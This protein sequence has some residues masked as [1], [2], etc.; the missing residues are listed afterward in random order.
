[1]KLLRYPPVRYELAPPGSFGIQ[2]ARLDSN[3]AQ[4]KHELGVPHSDAYFVLLVLT[5]GAVRLQLDFVDTHLMAPALLL[6]QPGQ[7]HYLTHAHDP[8]GYVVSFYPTQV[9]AELG[10]VLAQ[11]LVT[12]PSF[13]GGT[14]PA[15]LAAADLLTLILVGPPDAYRLLAA[16]AALTTLLTLC[17]SLV[18]QAAASLGPPPRPAALEQQFRRLVQLRYKEWKKPAPYAQQLHLTPAYLNQVL[19]ATTGQAA[20]THL[21]QRVVLEAKRLL[22]FTELSVQA[23]SA[24]LGYDDPNYFTRLFRKL[25]QQ[26][27][28]EFRDQYRDWC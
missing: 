13:A 24:E 14:V 15:L 11:Q 16:Q 8:Q 20:S 18:D 2:A 12:I 17:V 9:T 23:I 3:Y 21:Q 5:K 27:P 22:A 19:Q 1:M 4:G 7:V 6:M 10:Q 25:V 26:S 28:R